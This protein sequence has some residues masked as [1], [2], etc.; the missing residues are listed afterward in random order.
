[1]AYATTTDSA[2][3]GTT[4]YSI[5]ADSTSLPTETTDLIAQVILEFDNM[6]AGDVYRIRMYETGGI[7]KGVL[8]E[9]VVSGVQTEPKFALPPVLLM[10]GYDVTVTKLAGT[11]RTIGWAYS[12]VT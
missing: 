8:G 5:I 10:V 9:W 7:D 12:R 2:T 11:D 4:E 6:A 1:M 3:I